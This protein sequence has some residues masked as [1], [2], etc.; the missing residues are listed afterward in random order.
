MMIPNSMSGPNMGGNYFSSHGGMPNSQG[1]LMNSYQTG[2]ISSRQEP[3][4]IVGG[5]ED[6]GFTSSFKFRPSNMNDFGRIVC[7]ATNEIGSTDCSYDIKL[8]GVPN[9][10]TGCTH[11]MKNTSAIISCQVGFHQVS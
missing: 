2:L 3:S 4:K 10:P 9:P 7:K 5:F 8:G 11:N 1:N 6:N